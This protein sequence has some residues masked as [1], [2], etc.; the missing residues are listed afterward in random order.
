MDDIFIAAQTAG[1][2]GEQESYFLDEL[3]GQEAL[4]GALMD[5]FLGPQPLD[6]DM[7]ATARS[8]LLLPINGF[9]V[10]ISPMQVVMTP[11]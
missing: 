9:T 6:P 8:M 7:A 2:V 1:L 11:C 10:S 4:S 5:M 3:K